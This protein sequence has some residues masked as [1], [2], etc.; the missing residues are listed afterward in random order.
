MSLLRSFLTKESITLFNFQVSM[1]ILASLFVLIILVLILKF[2]KISLNDKLLDILFLTLLIMSLFI[3][4]TYT[5]TGES[6]FAQSINFRL[7]S[8]IAT[9][10]FVKQA[11]K[12][13]NRIFGN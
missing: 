1:F 5:L 12:T 3:A 4:F 7:Y 9:V 11:V 8:L 6:L 2:K 10:V 13:W